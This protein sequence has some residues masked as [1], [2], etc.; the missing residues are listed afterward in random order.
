MID[1]IRHTAPSTSIAMPTFRRGYNARMNVL[2][3]AQRYNGVIEL[4]RTLQE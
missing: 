3:V 2:K 1:S 4:V